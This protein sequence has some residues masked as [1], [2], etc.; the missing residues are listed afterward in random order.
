MKNAPVAL[1]NFLNA[2]GVPGFRADLFTLTLLSGTVYRWTTADANITIG[3][4]TWLSDGTVLS[5]GRIRQTARLEIDVLEVLLG[6]V[7]QLGGKSIALNA[8]QGVFDEARLQLDHLVGAFPGDVSLGP[9]LGWFEGRVA[10]VE[11]Q[12]LQTRM[13]VQSDIATLNQPLPRFVWSLACSNAVYDPNCGLNKATFTLS[14]AASGVPTKTTVPT[15]TAALTAK[16]AG[17]FNLGVLAFTSGVNN[18]VRRA[19]QGWAGNTFTLG[20][21]LPASP[22]GGDTFTVYPGCPRTTAAC[23]GTFNNLVNIRGFP[24]TPAPEAVT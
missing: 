12:G 7:A 11:P 24:H 1:T 5:R 6:S 22:A 17:Y 16:A 15:T 3:P 9:V 8:I 20:L 10:G 14:G 13:M 18:G 4:N 23:S 2:G 21:P 19:V